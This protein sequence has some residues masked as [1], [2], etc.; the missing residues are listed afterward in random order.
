MVPLPLVPMDL[1]MEWGSVCESAPS[2]VFSC[3]KTTYSLPQIPVRDSYSELISVPG[4]LGDMSS[5]VSV[6]GV[7]TFHMMHPW[8]LGSPNATSYSTFWNSCAGCYGFLTLHLLSGPQAIGVVLSSF[9]LDLPAPPV[10][11]PTFYSAQSINSS[12]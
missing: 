2:C 3:F 12:A 4:S 5:M 11:C 10:T 7:T 9:I 6:S 1:S 8:V